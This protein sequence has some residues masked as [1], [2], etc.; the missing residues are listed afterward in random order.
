MSQPVSASD[1]RE[2]IKASLQ[3]GSTV[4]TRL[5]W[6]ELDSPH[7]SLEG[8]AAGWLT[9]KRPTWGGLTWDAHPRR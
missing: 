9:P 3:C 6:F 5:P 8:Q 1:I 4:G 7:V 2:N